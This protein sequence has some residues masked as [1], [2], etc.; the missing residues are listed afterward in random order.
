[1]PKHPF[2]YLVTAS[3]LAFLASC[4]T[5]D[6]VPQQEE[7]V[8]VQ[9]R[10]EVIQPVVVTPEPQ[11]PP[12]IAPIQLDAQLLNQ[13]TFYFDFDR[14][15]LRNRA[16]TALDEHAKKIL[17]LLISN[18]NLNVT[19]AGHTDNRGTIAYNNALGNLRAEAVARYLRVKGV[20]GTN[21]TTVSYGELRPADDANNET[22]WQLNR[23]AVVSY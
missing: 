5:D 22:A 7:V 8:E 15:N 14:A 21:I 10:V 19:V 17:E 12:Q 2:I 20:P 11:Q 13:R 3:F 6:E 16:L 4:S 1:M 23:R 9:E 18:P